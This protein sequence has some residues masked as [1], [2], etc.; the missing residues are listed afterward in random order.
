MC[1]GVLVWSVCRCV[2]VVCVEDVPVAEQVRA[3]RA[4]HIGRSCT[5]CPSSCVIEFV[6][7]N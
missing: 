7:L 2:Y 3:G 1:S 4:V 5:S 6:C